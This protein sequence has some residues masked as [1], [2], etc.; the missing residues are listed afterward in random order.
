LLLGIGPGGHAASLF[1]DQATLAERS[2]LVIGVQEAGLEPYVPRISL[3]LPA[4]TSA[5]Q[6]VFLATGESKAEAVAAAFGPDAREDPHV[7][8]SMVA[9]GADEVT[10]LLDPPAAGKLR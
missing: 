6:V 5:K 9:A 10:V 8:A 2:R 7:P 4:L 3:T 1:P